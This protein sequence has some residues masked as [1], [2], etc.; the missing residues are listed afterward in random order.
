[1]LTEAR[2]RGCTKN[3]LPPANKIF[4]VNPLH[5][6]YGKLAGDWALR[7]RPIGLLSMSRAISAFGTGRFSLD[8]MMR[9]N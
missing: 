6:P 3:V 1:M 4:A 2:P 9:K 8:A 5:V 7:I